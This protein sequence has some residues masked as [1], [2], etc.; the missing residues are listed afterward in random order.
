M[1]AEGAHEAVF[2]HNSAAGSVLPFTTTVRKYL[3][4]IAPV[5][6]NTGVWQVRFSKPGMHGV[7]ESKLAFTLLS[8]CCFPGPAVSV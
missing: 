6:R 2:V 5:R 3:S 7:S 8:F 4:S 1:L